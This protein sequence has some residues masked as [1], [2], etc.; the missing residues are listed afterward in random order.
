MIDF[1]SFYFPRILFFC[2]VEVLFVVWEMT[3]LVIISKQKYVNGKLSP[4]TLSKI[5]YM[6]Q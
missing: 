6:S 3:Q 2:F 1:V 5:A 4:H